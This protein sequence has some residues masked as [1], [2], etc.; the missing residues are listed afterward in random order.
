MWRQGVSQNAG[1]LVVLVY[2]TVVECGVLLLPSLLP[3]LDIKTLWPPE[4][5]NKILDT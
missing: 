5:L 4:D 3:G 2:T 1:I